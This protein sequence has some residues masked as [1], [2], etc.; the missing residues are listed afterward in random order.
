MTNSKYQYL[1]VE[2]N[3]ADY[4]YINIPPTKI[5]RDTIAGMCVSLRGGNFSRANVYSCD[6][7]CPDITTRK[8]AEALSILYGQ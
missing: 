2:Y 5:D 7:A 3:P 8:I 6:F 1:T 4:S